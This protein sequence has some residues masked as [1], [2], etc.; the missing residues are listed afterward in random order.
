MR[1]EIGKAFEW[2]SPCAP[3]VRLLRDGRA[4]KAVLEFLCTT[5]VGCS[6]VEKVPPEEDEGEDSDGEEGGLG[7]L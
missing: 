2:K 4:T 6:G 5:R 3:T 7:P 1:K